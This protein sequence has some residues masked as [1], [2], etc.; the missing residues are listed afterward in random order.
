MSPGLSVASLKHIFSSFSSPYFFWLC[1]DTLADIQNLM[2]PYIKT[3]PEAQEASAVAMVIG[4]RVSARGKVEVA[5]SSPV[6]SSQ[7]LCT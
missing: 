4:V 6:E 2:T 7:N 5:L 1:L 3:R